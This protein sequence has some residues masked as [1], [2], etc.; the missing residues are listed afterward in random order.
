M[1]LTKIEAIVIAGFVSL[2]VLLFGSWLLEYYMNTYTIFS[3]IGL[4]FLGVLLI[5]WHNI[6]KTRS[7]LQA[8]GIKKPEVETQATPTTAPVST[9]P[10]IMWL[11]GKEIM[12]KYDLSAIELYQH[13]HKGLNI[14][15]KDF[16][17]IMLGNEAQPLTDHDIS[18][19]VDYDISHSEEMYDYL[20]GYHF[21]VR[22]VEEYLKLEK[23]ST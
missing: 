22:E 1:K 20:K 3:A 21:K 6:W 8:A 10:K 18:F 12:K 16:E 2:I 13:I 14:Y 11:T 4:C 9:F 15:P 19:E 23:R 5:V 7:S 17:T